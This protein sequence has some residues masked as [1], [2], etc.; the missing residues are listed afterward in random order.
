[1][2]SVFLSY[3]S[4]DSPLVTRVYNDLTRA[5]VGDVWC[6]ELT[7]R[8]GINFREEYIQKIRSAQAFIL[9]DSQHSRVSPYVRQEIEICLSTPGIATLVCLA[10][11]KGS[12]RRNEAFGGQNDIVFFEFADYD[13]DIRELCAHLQSTYVPRFT[14]PRDKDFLDEVNAAGNG[15]PAKVRQTILDKYEFFRSVFARD[16][17]VAEAQLVVL[18]HEH[19]E[20]VN[21]S[22]ISPLLAL[23]ALR[24]ESKKY[25]EA[26][27]A[28]TR[29][30]VRAPD[31]PRGWAGLGAAL[32]ELDDHGA[33]T[34]AWV[35]CLRLIEQ[36]E[37]PDAS[38][39]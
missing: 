34:T 39:F 7:G 15:F 4:Q 38:E 14:M 19:L 25:K 13:R 24:N 30:T 17:I 26:A 22:V 16:P 29:A 2:P 18:I 5:R 33:A 1:M 36:I 11:P 8:Y 32:S 9:F 6:Y 27:D 10:E 3:A 21:A 31:D 23:G 20:P 28:F 35:K 12:W 37:Q